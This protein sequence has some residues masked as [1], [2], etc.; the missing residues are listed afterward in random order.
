MLEEA[1]HLADALRKLVQAS[2]DQADELAVLAQVAV[3]ASMATAL[4]NM[5]RQ[6]R[7]TALQLQGQIVC[8]KVRYDVT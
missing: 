6:K 5:A 1:Q 2:E 3:P 7:V 8:L 4:Y